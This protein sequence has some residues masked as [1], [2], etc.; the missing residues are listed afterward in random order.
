MMSS[1][2]VCAMKSQEGDS[3]LDKCEAMQPNTCPRDSGT[4]NTLSAAFDRAFR[5]KI[6]LKHLKTA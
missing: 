5:M 1:P 2:L 3:S 4:N 6:G